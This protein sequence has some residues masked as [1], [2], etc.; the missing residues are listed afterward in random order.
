MESRVAYTRQ[1]RQQLKTG[2]YFD[3]VA[4]A[5]RLPRVRAHQPREGAC[6]AGDAAVVHERI[7]PSDQSTHEQELGVR[8]R[9]PTVRMRWLH[10]TFL[11]LCNDA[12]FQVE[13]ACRSEG[14]RSFML[15]S[16]LSQDFIDF[17]W[18][19][20]LR[21][22]GLAGVEDHCRTIRFPF[23]RQLLCCTWLRSFSILM[24]SRESWQEK[25]NAQVFCSERSHCQVSFDESSNEQ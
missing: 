8:L 6:V 18:H 3:L 17:S 20:L 1:R 25:G 5:C 10:R 12:Q 15:L 2:E 23:C 19:A 16:M 4:D 13:R 11:S 7:T 22:F 14:Y 21:S 24:G 9:Y